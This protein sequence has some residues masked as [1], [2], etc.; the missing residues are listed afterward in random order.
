[1]KQ[2]ITKSQFHDAFEA[3]RPDNFSYNGLDAL[4]EYLEAY[5]E[6]TGEEM[7]LDVIAICCDF[8]EYGSLKEF[9]EDNGSD[10]TSE[11]LEESTDVISVGNGD[12]II[13]QAF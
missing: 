11:N 2:T 1:M 9:N 10:L 12:E 13:V 4:F 3:I 8:T 5:E 6:G 7:E